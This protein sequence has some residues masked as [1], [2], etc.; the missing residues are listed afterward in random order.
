MTTVILISSPDFARGCYKGEFGVNPEESG[1][2]EINGQTYWFCHGD[3]CNGGK[4]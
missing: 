2:Q 1:P 4:V 3:F